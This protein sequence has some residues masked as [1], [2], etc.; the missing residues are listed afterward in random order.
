MNGAALIFATAVMGL[1]FED[2]SQDSGWDGA[3]ESGQTVYVSAHQAAASPKAASSRG[4]VPVHDC[5]LVPVPAPPA[6]GTSGVART[7]LTSR[8]SLPSRRTT[9]RPG[10]RSP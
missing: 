9:L 2:G 5:A 4:G 3:S 1:R 10:C 7:P 8:T 6:P